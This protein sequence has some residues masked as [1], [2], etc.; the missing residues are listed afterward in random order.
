M[1]GHQSTVS[2]R[3]GSGGGGGSNM[4]SYLM[5]GAGGSIKPSVSFVSMSRK[6]YKQHHYT[7]EQDG[8]SSMQIYGN[9]IAQKDRF[10]NKDNYFEDERNTHSS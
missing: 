7:D 4:M 10:P 5:N 6:E 1:I 8:P 9:E 3:G 2:A